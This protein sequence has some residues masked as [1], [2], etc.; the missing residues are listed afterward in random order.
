MSAEENKDWNFEAQYKA[1]NDC[2]TAL[3]SGRLSLDD[4]LASYQNGSGLVQQCRSILSRA[5]AKVAQLSAVDADGSMETKP[6]QLDVEAPEGMKPQAKKRAS[7]E[8][9]F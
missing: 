7:K 3:E 9:F 5:Q 2:V 1:L 8:D 6:L 4:S